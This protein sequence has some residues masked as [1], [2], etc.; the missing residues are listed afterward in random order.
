MILSKEYL[1]KYWNFRS[2][3]VQEIVR[4]SGSHQIYMQCKKE[5][6]ACCEDF[7]IFPIEYLCIADDLNYK[8]YTPDNEKCIFLKVRSCTI[9]QYRPLICR[10]HEL[11]L[12]RYN[13]EGDER[14][15]YFCELNFRNVD[16]K[17]FTFENL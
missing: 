4:I 16:S 10:T 3:I 14:N 15:L 2:E 11:P 7:N 1:E 9:Y 13:E 12:I 17:I 5:H 8:F 6:D